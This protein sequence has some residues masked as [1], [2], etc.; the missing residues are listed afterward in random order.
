MDIKNMIKENNLRQWEIAENL[1]M[2]EFTL[3]RWLRRPE[4]LG[5]E[6]REKI[7]T[8]IKQLL[9]KEE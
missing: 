2:S 3:S 9:A 7:E 6:K 5:K 8:A 1:R 4:K